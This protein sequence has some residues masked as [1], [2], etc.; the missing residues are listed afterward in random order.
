M[1]SFDHSVAWVIYYRL[2]PQ[3]LRLTSIP[4]D[5]PK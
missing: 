3:M 4:C 1:L 2:I 5:S